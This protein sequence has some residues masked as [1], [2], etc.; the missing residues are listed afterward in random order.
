MRFLERLKSK[1]Y[2][3]L[4][5][6]HLNGT[7]PIKQQII[8]EIL[9]EKVI[10]GDNPVTDIALDIKESNEVH[11]NLTAEM[12]F[13]TKSFNVILIPEKTEYAP[14]SPQ[15]ICRIRDTSYKVIGKFFYLIKNLPEWLEIK[16]DRI[17][18]DL[19]KLLMGTDYSEIADVL[20][21]ARIRQESTRFL[22]DFQVNNS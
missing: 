22:I 4:R 17:A 5:G 10:D 21:S 3:D 18:V 9:K 7:V 6:L 8:N 14:D 12:F 16:N 20:K 1:D 11:V 19:K 2:S 13:I 15:V